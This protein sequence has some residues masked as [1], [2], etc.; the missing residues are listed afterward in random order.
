[1]AKNGVDPLTG[2]KTVN[3]TEDGIPTT[4]N[5][6]DKGKPGLFNDIGDGGTYD[7]I[8]YD[9]NGNQVGSSTT[10]FV[11]VK[12]LG[13]DTFKADITNTLDFGNGNTI[14]LDGTINVQKFEALKP[15]NIDIVGGTGIY[16]DVRGKATINQLELNVLDNV[17]IS[18]QII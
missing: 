7:S 4:F 5:F 11:F 2:Q 10:E 15:A 12:Q 16:E 14:T 9:K 18:L 17:G 8:L 13:N 1:M 6:V 3:L